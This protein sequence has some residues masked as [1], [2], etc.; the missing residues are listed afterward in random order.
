MF[1]LFILIW[2]LGI[3]IYNSITL[4]PYSLTVPTSEKPL[5]I[6][7]SVASTINKTTILCNSQHR[8]GDLYC[9]TMTQARTHCA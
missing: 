2:E 3:I 5:H 9:H 8:E 6:P 1:T 4:L 7:L